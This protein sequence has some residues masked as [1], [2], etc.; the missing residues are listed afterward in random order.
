ML[1]H[2]PLVVMI[3]W[4]DA[5]SDLESMEY[6]DYLVKTVGWL[7]EDGPKF[8]GLADELLPHDNG[9]R[10]HTRIP[11]ECVVEREV[12][13]PVPTLSL[14]TGGSVSGTQ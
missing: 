13:K 9:F 10:G 14:M 5:H 2:E 12:I 11:I 3:T 4:R 6:D 7:I 8:V 1:E